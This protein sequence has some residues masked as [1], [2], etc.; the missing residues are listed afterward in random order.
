MTT[1]VVTFSFGTTIRLPSPP[2]TRV[3]V[4]AMS[5]T[6]PLTSSPIEIRSPIRIG[7]V[8]TISTPATRLAITWRPAKPM[9]MP[10]TAVEASTPVA[11]RL[12]EANW[13]SASATPIRMIATNR[14]RRT[15][16]AGASLAGEL[17]GLESH[18]PL[19]R[20]A[21]QE[22]IDADRDHDRDGQ[23]DRGRDLVAVLLPE[24]L[25]HWAKSPV[26]EY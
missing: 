17:P 12:I 11:N 3:K 21:D 10:S 18:R 15:R 1:S 25:V 6:R 8:I 5:I 9:M 23:R 19:H 26:G 20:P 14:S 7:W 4:S 13:L 24:A 2:S 16:E 22:A